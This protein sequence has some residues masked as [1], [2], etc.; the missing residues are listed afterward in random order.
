MVQRKE[1]EAVRL[2]EKMKE[3]ERTM[4]ELELRYSS[5]SV[6]LPPSEPIH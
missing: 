5:E 2:E 6:S 3:M 4:K 1:E